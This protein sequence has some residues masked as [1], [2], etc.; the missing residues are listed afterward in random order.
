M[1]RLSCR[2]CF[3]TNL[4]WHHF[5][6]QSFVL[7]WE[8]ERMLWHYYFANHAP[9]SSRSFMGFSMLLEKSVYGR[10]QGIYQKWWRE[11]NWPKNYWK[12]FFFYY[13]HRIYVLNCIAM[14]LC[15]EGLTKRLLRRKTFSE[16]KLLGS[17]NLIHYFILWMPTP[18]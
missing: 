10:D 1:R 12:H 2:L 14:S 5:F 9:N 8:N 7:V 18:L 11:G 15:W 3:S 17:C 13:L 6:L 4:S 16:Y